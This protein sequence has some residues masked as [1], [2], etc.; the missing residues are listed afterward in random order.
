MAKQ[1]KNN[2]G[3]LFV[4]HKKKTDKHPNS[5]GSAL[6]DGIE[7]WIA[8]WTH[9]TEGGEKYMSLAFTPKEAET[10]SVQKKL[11]DEDIPF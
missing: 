10:G 3:A 4:N 1:Q 7:Y 9:Q 11:N 2:S 5:T 6:I 8:A